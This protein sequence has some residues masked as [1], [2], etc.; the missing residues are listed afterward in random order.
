MSYQ[1]YNSIPVTPISMLDRNVPI[2]E[3][4]EEEFVEGFSAPKMYKNERMPVRSMYQQDVQ[5]PPAAPSPQ[6]L[7]P[8][9]D[10]SRDVLCELRNIKYLLAIIAL[11]MFLL[12]LFRR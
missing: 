7:P 2:F 6:P 4:K 10:S 3:E 11:L 5:Q 12:L 1:P 8:A 9:S